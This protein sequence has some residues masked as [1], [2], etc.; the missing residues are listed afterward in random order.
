MT[1]K[2]AVTEGEERTEEEKAAEGEKEETRGG[3][4]SMRHW[5][6]DMPS[7]APF[8]PHRTS[9]ACEFSPWL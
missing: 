9:T 1:E 8:Q 4:Q 6:I 2:L 5:T 7:S 3:K